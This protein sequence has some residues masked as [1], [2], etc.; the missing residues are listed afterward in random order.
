[1]IE[2][3][4]A[5]LGHID[6]EDGL[7]EM[8]K[9][10]PPVENEH[11]VFMFVQ[12]EVPGPTVFADCPVSKKDTFSVHWDVSTVAVA[13]TPEYGMPPNKNFASSKAQPPPTDEA[14]GIKRHV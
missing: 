11:D 3:P 9:S 14:L 12:S 8:P 10:G 7:A 6:I 5:V 1:M 4:L 13:V 2:G